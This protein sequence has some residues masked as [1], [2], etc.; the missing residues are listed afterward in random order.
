MVI[1]ISSFDIFVPKNAT[2]IYFF[3]SLFII[4]FIPASMCYCNDVLSVISESSWV[5]S[6]WGD[7][8]GGA[9]IGAWYLSP[10]MGASTWESSSNQPHTAPE[11]WKHL[12]TLTK[13]TRVWCRLFTDG[14]S[15]ARGCLMEFN[16]INFMFSLPF[17]DALQVPVFPRTAEAMRVGRFQFWFCPPT[18]PNNH[19]SWLC[20]QSPCLGKHKTT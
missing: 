3:I 5:W 9:G 14:H 2:C 10:P 11:C 6:V 18:D 12:L 17:I 1:P 4:L 19:E 8:S 15:V 7:A 13:K 16:W 20:T